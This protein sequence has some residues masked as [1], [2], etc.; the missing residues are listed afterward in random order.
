MSV[1]KNDEPILDGRRAVTAAA[2]ARQAI[3]TALDSWL[4]ARGADGRSR[5]G[6][7]DDFLCL[8]ALHPDPD[9][10]HQLH[11]AWARLSEA[12]HATSYDLPPTSDE[13]ES[14]MRIVQQFIK[15]E[16]QTLRG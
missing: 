2:L 14:W 16:E 9:L 6:R 5:R 12:C 11:N 3:E 8:G 7:R 10:A 15:Y 4:E 13:L 1:M